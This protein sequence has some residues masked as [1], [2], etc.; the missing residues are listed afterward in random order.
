MCLM[1]GAPLGPVNISQICAASVVLP[2]PGVP[3]TTI[4]GYLA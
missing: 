1:T 2:V 3:V 4:L